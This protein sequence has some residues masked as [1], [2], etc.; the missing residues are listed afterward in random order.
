[1]QCRS[2]TEF[3]E[4]GYCGVGSKTLYKIFK[5]NNMTIEIQTT[6]ESSIDKIWEYWTKPEHI[7]NWNYALEEWCCP[8]AKNDFRVGREFV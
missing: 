5:K 1:M 4:V 7:L 3:G 2:A 8:S 6:I